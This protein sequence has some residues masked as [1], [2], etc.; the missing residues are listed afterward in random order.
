L[1][2]GLF[3][4]DLFHQIQEF[5]DS[6]CLVRHVSVHSTPVKR[7]CQVVPSSLINV[8]NSLIVAAEPVASR[9]SFAR[10]LTRRV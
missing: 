6:Q 9:F 4:L 10:S 5:L 1:R 7:T 8:N 3:S 2:V